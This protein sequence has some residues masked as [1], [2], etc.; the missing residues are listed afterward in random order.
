[1]QIHEMEHKTIGQVQWKIN[2]KKTTHKMEELEQEQRKRKKGI[3][4]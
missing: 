2:F 4:K 1:M 3:E